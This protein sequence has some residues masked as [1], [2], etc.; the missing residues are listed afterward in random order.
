MWASAEKGRTPKDYRPEMPPLEGAEYLIDYLFEVGPTVQGA[1]GP[2]RL[3][4][5]ELLAWKIN[6][7]IRL[8]PWES[9]FLIKLS[10]AYLQE[11]QKAEKILAVAPWIAEVPDDDELRAVAKSLKAQ[12]GGMAA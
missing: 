3:T 12:I 1:M 9:R 10:D 7:G 11:L 8:L 6:T 2:G 4:N 5:E